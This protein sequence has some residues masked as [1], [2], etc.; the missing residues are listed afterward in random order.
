[1]V[2]SRPRE[3]SGAG[4]V[5]IEGRGAGPGGSHAGS[6]SGRP[7]CKRAASGASGGCC[8]L[9]FGPRLLPTWFA[10]RSRPRRCG[11]RAAVRGR[12]LEARGLALSLVVG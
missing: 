5:D 7:G 10:G 8:K 3:G 12:Q 11:E 9:D 4:G 1:M 6:C 2:G